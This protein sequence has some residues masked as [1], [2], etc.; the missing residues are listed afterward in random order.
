MANLQ[1]KKQ[2]EDDFAAREVSHQDY[3][4][5]LLL[6]GLQPSLVCNNVNAIDHDDLEDNQH[7]YGF[8]YGGGAAEI[9]AQLWQY[10]PSY[11]RIENKVDDNHSLSLHHEN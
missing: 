8:F 9:C 1:D 5:H 10:L 6:L 4:E 2:E 3:L 11:N 7:E